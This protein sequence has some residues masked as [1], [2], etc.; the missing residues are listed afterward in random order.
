MEDKIKNIMNEIFKMNITDD[1]S[2]S[3]TDKWDSFTH[4]DLIVKLENEFN[5]SFS[6]EEMGSI[7]SYLDIVKIIQNKI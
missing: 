5:I 7:E 4:L 6:P 3:S 2:K 1:F